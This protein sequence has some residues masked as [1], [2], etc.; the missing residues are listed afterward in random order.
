MTK[1]PNSDQITLKHN[2]LVKTGTWVACSRRAAAGEHVPRG[3]D[4]PTRDFAA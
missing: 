1:C 3:T 4:M 2:L